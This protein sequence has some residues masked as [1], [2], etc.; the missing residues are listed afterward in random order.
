MTLKIGARTKLGLLFPVVCFINV[1]D[2]TLAEQMYRDKALLH[3]LEVDVGPCKWALTQ[4]GPRSQQW[5]ILKYSCQYPN[6]ICPASK[7][8]L[9]F[10]WRSE[11]GEEALLAEYLKNQKNVVILYQNHLT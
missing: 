10:P 1:L 5:R 7:I 6:Y 2:Q 9:I 3:Q 11:E 4:Y 8:S